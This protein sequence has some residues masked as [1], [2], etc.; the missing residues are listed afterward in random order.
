MA[1]ALTPLVFHGAA[2]AGLF[3]GATVPD[4]VYSFEG[5]N[6][7]FVVSDDDDRG[8]ILPRHLIE[9]AHDGKR[10]LAVERRAGLVGENESGK[11]APL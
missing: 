8:V 11:A 1:A 7:F 3:K 9:D 6:D 10:P 5:R 2:L 4:V